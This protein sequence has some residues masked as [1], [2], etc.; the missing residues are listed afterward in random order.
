MLSETKNE[1]IARGGRLLDLHCAIATYSEQP[2]GCKPNTFPGIEISVIQASRK[3]PILHDSAQLRI[4]RDFQAKLLSYRLTNYQKVLNSRFGAP[5]LTSPI[6]EI[7]RSLGACTPDDADLQQEV[8][9]LLKARDAQIRSERWVEVNI[10]LIEALLG[11]VHEGKVRSP[12]VGQIA[13]AA[14]VILAYRDDKQELEARRVGEI[15]RQL[16]LATEPRDGRGVK[17]ILTPA[18]SRRIHELA[19]DCDV[20]SVQD[21]VKRC[22]FCNFGDAGRA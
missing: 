15:L 19:R 22:E 6:R 1:Y 16:N 8:I 4:S 9:N 2:G 20:P 17:L 13:E 18:V 21:G 14:S 3:L 5:E 11:L 12:Y 10:V 7:A